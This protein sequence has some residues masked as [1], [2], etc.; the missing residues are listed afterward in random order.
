MALSFRAHPMALVATAEAAASSSRSS[1]SRQP[2]T[3]EAA[4]VELRAV[5]SGRREGETVTFHR[6][7]AIGERKFS[8]ATIVR[9]FRTGSRAKLLRMLPS[10]TLF[11]SKL[12]D[13][14]QEH[15]LMCAMRQMNRRWR[16][17][18]LSVCGIPVEALAY[19]IFPLG[20][21]AGLVEAVPESKTLCELAAG[22][23]MVDRHRR[24]LE[25]LR[26]DPG[27]LDQLAATIVGY[28][29]VSYALGIR[30]GH[31]ENLMLRSDGS[32]FRVDFGFCFGRTPE[33]DTPTI[34]VPKAVAFALG[35]ERW[36]EVVRVSSDALQA[37]SGDGVRTLSLAGM[38]SFAPVGVQPP[39]WDLL[40]CVPEMGPLLGEAHRY[41]QT[42]SIEAF[43]REVQH[44][45]EWSL[46][47]TTKN[48]VRQAVRFLAIAQEAEV[49]TQK[50]GSHKEWVDLLDP[51][52]LMCKL[53]AGN[54]ALPVNGGFGT[55][56]E[57]L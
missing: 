26:G 27:C 12:G 43:E 21:Q 47:R 30:D 42:L 51:L 48:V 36:S 57:G 3:G 29:T 46:S 24:V 38:S 40:R 10:G 37:I 55:L 52:G 20:T 49:S 32:F 45:D 1:G 17:H 14:S 23:T 33:I 4:G 56:G 11:I 5:L 13:L 35:P 34:F 41:V 50:A 16:Q 31:D 53:S 28:L 44:A 25:E 7:L 54:R 6:P 39:A 2:L 15:A 18:G 22:Y 8:Q 19:G 9:D